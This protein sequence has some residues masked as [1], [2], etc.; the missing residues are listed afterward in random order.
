M[1]RQGARR[2]C[3]SVWCAVGDAEDEP[4]RSAHLS[5]PAHF[6]QALSQL[7]DALVERYVGGGARL[8]LVRQ[9]L[10]D[11]AQ[12][13]LLGLEFVRELDVVNLQLVPLLLVP[14]GAGAWVACA[15]AACFP[16]ASSGSIAAAATVMPAKPM[17]TAADI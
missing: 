10:V 4:S 11:V 13:E 8:E 16:I 7:R 2:H 17:G 12:V 15:W 6:L 14:A 5:I 3:L 9:E 1:R